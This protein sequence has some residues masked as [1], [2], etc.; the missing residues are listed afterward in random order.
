ML[1][2]YIYA[3]VCKHLLRKIVILKYA[4]IKNL[5]C[6]KDIQKDKNLKVK[7]IIIRFLIFFF[8]T[9]CLYLYNSKFIKEHSEGKMSFMVFTLEIKI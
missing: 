9:K 8:I 1:C 6:V 4:G 5:S 7:D 3:C 2:H